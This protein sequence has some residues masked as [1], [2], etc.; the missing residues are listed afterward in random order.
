MT[1]VALALSMA[2]TTATAQTAPAPAPA[3]A[4]TP[5]PAAAASKYNL[6]TPIETIVADPVAKAVLDANV[7]N[8]S[9]HPSYDMF[10]SMSLRQVA[11]MSNGVLTD[12]MLA[13]TEKALAAIK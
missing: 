3:A 13:K 8:T 9:T 7:P 10:K 4:A 2:L 5:A 11:P 12:E 6:D 1:F